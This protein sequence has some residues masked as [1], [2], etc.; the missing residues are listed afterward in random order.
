MGSQLSKQVERRKAI[1]AEKKILS[2]LLSS[3]GDSF[4]C[5]DFHPSDRSSWMT[6]L[7][8]LNKLR[9]SHIVWPG[10]HDSATDRIGVPLITRPFAQ[11]QSRSI[12]SQLAV[13][14]RV[15]DVRVQQDRRVCHGILTTYLVDHVLSEL[16]RFLDDHPPSS[17][18]SR[19]APS[20]A[21]TIPRT[22]SPSSSTASLTA[23]FTR[24]TPS[25]HAPSP[26]SFPARS[27]ASGSLARPRSP[28][29]AGR[30]GARGI[31]GTTG[32]TRICPTPNSKAT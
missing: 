13:G 17:S 19:S 10:T 11:C 30:F 8:P 27:S 18:S 9:L 26:R 5:S 2:D 31:Y 20:L 12:Y 3:S 15:L 4:P 16:C 21:T 14:V 22:S 25:S 23:S 28:A 7:C 24:T 6:S 1:A 32:S 29:M